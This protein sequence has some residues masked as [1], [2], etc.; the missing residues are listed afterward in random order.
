V[1]PKYVADTAAIFK[2]WRGTVAAAGASPYI[3]KVGCLL[4]R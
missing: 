2:H 4:I 1:K 3:Q